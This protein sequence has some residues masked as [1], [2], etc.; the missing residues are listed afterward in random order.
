MKRKIVY[1]RKKDPD[2]MHHM[3]LAISHI[4]IERIQ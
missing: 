1:H 3:I 2:N 4:M